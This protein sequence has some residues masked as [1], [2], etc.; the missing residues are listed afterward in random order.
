MSSERG[1]NDNASSLLNFNNVVKTYILNRFTNTLKLLPQV[2]VKIT[3]FTYTCQVKKIYYYR[4]CCLT[5]LLHNAIFNSVFSEIYQSTIRLPGFILHDK[6]SFFQVVTN[7][8]FLPL[9]T[10]YIIYIHISNKFSISRQSSVFLLR[11]S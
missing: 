3:H 8:L 2:T 11:E 4:F 9:I 7:F 5:V 10:V 1:P 6:I